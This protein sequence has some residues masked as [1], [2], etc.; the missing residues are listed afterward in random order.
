MNFIIL[1]LLLT[2][3]II[4]SY[5]NLFAQSNRILN[6]A[7]ST[8]GANY[9]RTKAMAIDAFNSLYVMGQFRGTIDVD[10]GLGVH[11]I[12]AAGYSGFIQKLDA[13]G[14]FE[15]ASVL[16]GSGYIST[17]VVGSQGFIYSTTNNTIQKRGVSG[18]LIW[19]KTV[20]LGLG[21]SYY[22]KASAI[23]DSGDLYLIGDFQGTIDFDPGPDTAEVTAIGYK[24]FFIQKLNTDG[25][26]IW[27]KNIMDVKQFSEFKSIALGPSDDIYITG[28]FSDTLDFDPSPTV[29]NLI[30][31]DNIFTPNNCPDI[32]VLKLDSDGNFVWAINEGG[33]SCS[34]GYGA[35]DQGQAVAVGASG[36][37]YLT[38]SFIG[39][40]DFDPSSGTNIISSFN[41]SPDIFIQKLDS[42]GVP[43]WT[44]T[45]DGNYTN[46]GESMVLNENEDIYI[47]GSF[48]SLTDFDP[49]S[50]IF[51]MYAGPS[52]DDIYIQKLD[53]S[54]NFIWAE[55]VGGTNENE[56]NR[57]LLDDQNNIYVS[58]TYTYNTNL[59]VGGSEISFS[60]ASR[61][62]CLVFKIR[63]HGVIGNIYHD[64]NQD[65]LQTGNEPGLP[66]RHLIIQPGNLIVE[67]NG[68]G[69]WSIDSLPIG[70]YTI[71]VD[72]NGNWLP[73]CP[74]IQSF[75][76]T[77]QD[78]LTIVDKYGV[79]STSP[80]AAP[81][82]SIHT[83]FL[84]PG[85]SNQNVYVQVCN[86]AIATAILDSSYI[87]VELDSLL[88]IQSA[89]LPFSN[90][91]NN[92]YLF[93]IDSISLYPSICFDFAIQCSLSVDA[94]LGQT[95]CMEAKLYLQDSCLLDNTPNPYPVG[96]SPC[97]TIYDS[98]NLVINSSC[99]NDTVLF[100]IRNTGGNMSCWT[101]VR[102]YVDGQFS[103]M[104]SVQ[105]AS[106]DTIVFAYSGEGYTWRMEVDQHPLYLGASK[107][108]STIE[109]CGDILNWTSNL[110]NV[111]PHDDSDP[112][113]DI[114]CGLVTGSY[115]P[116][117]KTGYPLG[118]GSTHDI[119]PNQDLEY[120]IRFQNTGIDTA[121]TV[122]IRDTL[123]T[124]YDIFSVQ[125]GVSSHDY[126]FKMY[127]PRV[128]EWTFNNIMLPDSNVNEPSSH[129]FVKFKVKLNPGL[130][131]SAII[132]N[133]AAIYFDYN[134]PIITNTSWHTINENVF[135]ITTDRIIEE[136]MQIKVYPNP[137]TSL[138]NIVKNDDLEIRILVIDNLGRVLISKES[139][140]S[141]TQIDLSKIP[142][143]IYYLSINNGKQKTTQKII[144]Q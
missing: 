81:D 144:K 49:S 143:G 68:S 15:W 10:P 79:I 8:G 120:V 26:L 111:M 100:M 110:V 91:G 69:M 3:L 119:L 75:I 48:G 105:L 65:C 102:L 122:V 124:D 140:D 134:A 23:D 70:N 31:D 126:S 30:A 5:S 127:G 38:G 59:D 47:A 17:V 74:T 4:I 99:V 129:G 113:I 83:P 128:L 131:N 87:I 77:H 117:D 61:T 28:W 125:S 60:G 50:G 53:S 6:W 9:D 20:Q 104:D 19:S 108:S 95:L 40:A 96:I 14:N 27:V 41:N 56:P 67:T 112:A 57:I 52:G 136:Q 98:S 107:P 92:R 55:K 63:E 72:T 115:D 73:T 116:N 11:N 46:S 54:G 36:N 133:S 80:C 121:F 142:S 42:N 97:N 22:P 82:I 13:N 84:R 135:L 51:Q 1:K 2:T 137:T 130:L 39:N 78:S 43:I 85:F 88:T 33:R 18:N 21:G 16:P 35:L 138:V 141:I 76:V 89:S 24:G 64:F 29:Y 101:Q 7:T 93:D 118:V 106:G 94:I 66:N 12:S 139:S 71:T 103:L 62:E 86:D 45:L 109:L 90:L 32:L 44:K 132:E 58:G 123:S 114:Y 25:E 37:V 34:N